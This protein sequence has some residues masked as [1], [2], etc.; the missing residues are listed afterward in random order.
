MFS[1]L[2]LNNHYVYVTAYVLPGNMMAASGSDL[3]G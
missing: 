3:K 2:Q 1:L